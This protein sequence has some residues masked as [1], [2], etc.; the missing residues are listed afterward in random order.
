[1]SS[2]FSVICQLRWIK[3]NISNQNMNIP[4]LNTNELTENADYFL[5]KYPR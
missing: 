4:R 1:M 3:L 2:I 5:G